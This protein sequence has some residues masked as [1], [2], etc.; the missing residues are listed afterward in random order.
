MIYTKLTNKALK[1]AYNAHHGQVDKSGTPYIFHPYH[2]AEQMN[3]EISTC[4][5][6]LH[7]VVEDT[8]ITFE[9]LEKEFPSEV[10]EILHYLTHEKGVP[11]LDYVQKI[12]ENPIAVQIKL[13]DIAHNCDH[14]RFAGQVLS[15]EQQEYWKK[16]YSEALKILKNS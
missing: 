2:L 3:D 16:K 15:K 1:I 6:L 12:K 8:D 11:Y 13:A 10:I 14:S 9:D 5:A 7:D 4:A